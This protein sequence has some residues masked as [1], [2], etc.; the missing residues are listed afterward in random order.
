M[1][2]QEFDRAR[3]QDL[4]AKRQ[5]EEE[6]ARRRQEEEKLIKESMIKEEEKKHKKESLPP[7]P[8]ASDP[9]ACEIA[10]RL[11]SGKR[12]VR[13]F[14]KTN[15]IQA[16]Y[17]F[18]G[19]SAESELGDGNYEISQAIPRKIYANMRATL[20]EEGLVHKAALQVAHV[21]SDDQ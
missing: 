10:F 20:E 12:V 17:T 18:V 7:E 9:D 4:S 21:E 1:Q 16:L 5:H 13:R 14:L 15:T 3:E 11:P 6:E 8:S 19:L 2:R